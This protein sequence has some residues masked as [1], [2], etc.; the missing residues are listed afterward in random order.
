MERKTLA[1]R[2]LTTPPKK[3]RT[4]AELEFNQLIDSGGSPLDALNALTTTPTTRTNTPTATHT[5]TQSKQSVREYRQRREMKVRKAELEAEATGEVKV[6]QK[7]SGKRGGARPGAGR[8]LGS[9]SS[10]TQQLV[11]QLTAEGLSPLEYMLTNMR[12]V[13]NPASFR[14]EMAKAAAPYIHPKLSS[15]EL[16]GS[17]GRPLIPAVTGKVPNTPAEAVKYY[18]DLLG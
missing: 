17:G 16:T 1:R 15:T 13:S 5:P 9:L 18:K 12:D 10:R 6:N 2:T 11:A 8:P 7:I 14:A 3:T 4:Q